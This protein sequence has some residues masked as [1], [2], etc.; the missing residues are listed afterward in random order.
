MFDISIIQRS[1]AIQQQALIRKQFV[2]RIR[3]QAV[4]F[5]RLAEQQRGL[6]AIP[7]L[8]AEHQRDL[9]KISKLFAEHQRQLAEH[10]RDLNKILKLFVEQQ[11]QFAEQQRQA[12]ESFNKIQERNR[13]ALQRLGEEDWFLRPVDEIPKRIRKALQRLGEEGWFLDP[14]MPAILIQKIELLFDEHPDEIVEWLSDFFRTRLDVIE[15][16]LTDSYPHRGH[17]FQQAFEAHREGKYGL[18]IPVFLTQ[19]DGIFGERTSER[20]NLFISRQRERAC[21]EYVS[22]TSD[23]YIVIYLHPLSVLLPLWMNQYERAEGGDSFVGLNR[24]QVLHGESV[25]YGTEQN[26]LKAISLLNYLHWIFSKTDDVVREAI[27]E[28]K[29]TSHGQGLCEGGH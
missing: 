27:S 7:K 13:K 17:L 28:E 11:R 14:E 8:F 4:D 2:E 21:S 16:T 19:A 24:H 10:Q 9:N 22:Q 26:S 15:R 12:I 25:D 20:Q 23:N 3:F 29:E 1:K 18:S 5:D 6:N